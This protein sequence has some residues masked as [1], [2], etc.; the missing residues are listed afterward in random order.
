M[1]NT[2]VPAAAEGLP[3]FTRRSFLGGVAI[4]AI[5]SAAVAIEV[6][7]THNQALTPEQRIQVA[8]KEIEAAMAERFP[9]FLISATI[10]DKRP[11]IYKPGGFYE[12][13]ITRS[14]VS[15]YAYNDLYGPEIARWFVDYPELRRTAE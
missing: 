7:S 12:G 5:P 6:S 9:D 4:T 14:M 2:S 1:P 8:V 15:I 10:E 13:D 3:S 11:Q